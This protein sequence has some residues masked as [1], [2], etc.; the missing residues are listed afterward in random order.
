MLTLENI[1]V[2]RMGRPL[3]TKLSLSAQPGACVVVRGQNGAGK[4]TLLKV[5]AG[6]LPPNTGVVQHDYAHSMNF[7]T[8]DNALDESMSVVQNMLFWAALSGTHMLIPAALKFFHLEAMAEIPAHQ[9][10]QGTKR[11]LEL[12]RLM[13]KPADL[14]LLDEPLA[15]LDSDMTDVVLSLIASKC[16]QG[17]IVVMTAHAGHTVPFGAELYLADYASTMAVVA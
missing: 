15:N 9:L 11:R 1:T 3:F 7:I 6:L 14:W 10:S 13:L 2:S 5:I 12:A 16:D 4:T 17:G 8:H